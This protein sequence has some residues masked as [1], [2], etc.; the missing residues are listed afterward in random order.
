MD[1]CSFFQLINEESITNNLR[2]EIEQLE[3]RVQEID[4]LK[5]MED[6]IQSQRWDDI[7]QMART[8]QTVST[9]MARATSPTL[10]RKTRLEL[11]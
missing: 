11:P 2:I 8:M 4:R 9:T 3:V 6:L 1:D 10:L 5:S 7:S